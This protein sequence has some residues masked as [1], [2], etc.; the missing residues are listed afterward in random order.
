MSLP[1]PPGSHGQQPP[2]GGQ[3]GGGVPQPWSQPY[4]G[5]PSG[6]LPAGPPPWGPQQ[7]WAGGPPPRGGGRAKWILGGLAAILAVAL[8]VVITVLVV[9]PDGGGNGASNAGGA[10][11]D[12]EFA[13]ANDAGPV[14]IITEDP[15]C[16]SWTRVSQD[17]SDQTNAVNWGERDASVPATAWTPEQRRMYET[18][19]KAT[20]DAAARTQSLVK[21]TPHRVMREL[22]EQFVAYA[23]AFVEAVPTYAADQEGLPLTLNSVGLSLANICAA[24]DYGS[25]QA[26]APL[27]AVPAAPS[28]TS[29]TE[30]SSKQFLA[31]AN[32]IC[33]DWETLV[34]KFDADTTEWRKIDP[35]LSADKWNLEQR[36][37][38]NSVIPVLTA[39]ADDVERL[40]RQSG[41]AVL[42]D[43]AVL[44]AQ[45]QRGFAHALP[46]YRPADNLLSAVSSYTVKAV[47]WA[48]KV[49]S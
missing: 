45:Y 15:T 14:N 1:P 17:Y 7:Q 30:T 48:C 25:A 29:A 6:S 42:E 5:G 37:I 34:T 2:V 40:G 41:N 47:R 19:G 3:P 33:A 18:V 49:A 39:N 22:Y 44:A 23:N 31:E 46:N 26:V 32:P 13:S 8:V 28:A 12:S 36:E 11:A 43:F 35:Q 21:Q 16:A 38:N 27:I 9:R 20:T 10:G 4:R 24:I